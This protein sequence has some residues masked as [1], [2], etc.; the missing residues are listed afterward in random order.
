MPILQA[1]DPEVIDFI[2][3]IGAVSFA[4]ARL[5]IGLVVV[6][7]RDPV[8]GFDVDALQTTLPLD[9]IVDSVEIVLGG[10][11]KDASFKEMSLE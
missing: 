1:N 7:V 10:G 11:N 2:S 6:P 9:D 3:G 8:Q 5:R 4:V